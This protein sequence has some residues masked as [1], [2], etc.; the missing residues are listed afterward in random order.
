MFISS[1]FAAEFPIRNPPELANDD[2]GVDDDRDDNG[3]IHDVDDGD[4]GDECDDD[5]K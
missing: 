4:D 3:D 1:E 2:D 5:G